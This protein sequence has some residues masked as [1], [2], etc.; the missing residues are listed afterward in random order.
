MKNQILPFITIF[1]LTDTDILTYQTL[2][3]LF[4]ALKFT[5]FAFKIMR[6]KYMS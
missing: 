2:M 6:M 1:Y 3:Y 4:H 5:V